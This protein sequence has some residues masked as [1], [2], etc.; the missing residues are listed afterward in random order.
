[1][2]AGAAAED[3]DV[4]LVEIHGREDQMG[5]AS[6]GGAAGG[7]DA[8]PGASVPASWAEIASGLGG[9]ECTICDASPAEANSIAFLDL[10]FLPNRDITS[11]HLLDEELAVVQKD[12]TKVIKSKPKQDYHERDGKT[13]LTI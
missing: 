12:G 4:E 6:A 2:D 5:M 8:H 11:L 9:A 10:G 13:Q 7:P 3:T 1:M